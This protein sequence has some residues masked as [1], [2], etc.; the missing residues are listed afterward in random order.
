MGG[1]VLQK[2]RLGQ[3]GIEVS[4]IGLGTVKFGRNQ[5]VKY[6]SVFDLPSDHDINHLLAV[7]SELGIN[8]ID[9]APA[10]GSSEERLGQL[11]RG[12]RQDWIVSTKAGEEF[13]NGQSHFDFS[14]AAIRQS[15][16]RSLRRLHTDYLDIVLIHSNGD[17]EHIIHEDKVFETLEALKAVG[18][19]R[20]YGM[21][22]KTIA[23]GLLTLDHADMAMVCFNPAYTNEREVITHAHQHQKGIFIKKALASGHLHTLVVANPIVDTIKFI[24]SE[25]GVTSIIVGTINPAHLQE[26]SVNH[27]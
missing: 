18:K 12:K 24:L 14:P 17:D 1:C 21:S 20:S 16:D 13:V 15:I 22:T 23:G 7:A 5:G 9:T 11:L 19:I 8:L 25:P 4:V 2:R 10:Y 6:P 26:C 3:S 27:T